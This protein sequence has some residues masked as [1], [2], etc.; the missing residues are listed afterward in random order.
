MSNPPP[1]NPFGAFSGFGQTTTTN[2]ATTP[3]TGTAPT[4]SSLFGNAGTQQ[5]ASSP[6]SGLGGGTSSAP[7]PLFGSQAPLF[8]G[9]STTPATTPAAA[10]GGL[11]GGNT[12]SNTTGT[13]TNTAKPGL[14][15]NTPAAA[16]GGLFGNFNKPTGGTATS[17]APTFTG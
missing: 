2:N 7:K 16:P 6:F 3:G 9:T 11:F 17:T 12:T 5:A 8:G 4:G 1:N 13:A 15:G 14:F 10:P